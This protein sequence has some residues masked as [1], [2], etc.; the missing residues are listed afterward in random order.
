MGGDDVSIGRWEPGVDYIYGWKIG[1]YFTLTGSTG[2]NANALDEVSFIDAEFNPSDQFWAYS[3]S[4][5]L[6]AKFTRRSTGYFEWFGVFTDGRG[7]EVSPNFL[8]VGID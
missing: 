6:G 8:N 2:A 5:A 1:D 4:V 7:D 3:Q